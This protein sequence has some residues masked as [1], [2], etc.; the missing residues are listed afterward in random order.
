LPILPQLLGSGIRSEKFAQQRFKVVAP[1]MAKPRV[2]LPVNYQVQ[3]L[4]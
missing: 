2:F 3:K 4:F 1:A